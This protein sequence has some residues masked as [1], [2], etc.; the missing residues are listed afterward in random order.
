MQKKEEVFAVYFDEA[1]NDIRLST[2]KDPRYI[3]AAIK[4]AIKDRNTYRGFNLSKISQRHRISQGYFEN[5]FTKNLSYYGFSDSDGE[6]PEVHLEESS[7]FLRESNNS[8]PLGTNTRLF[9]TNYEKSE[10]KTKFDVSSED[11]KSIQEAEN[12]ADSDEEEADVSDSE[13]DYT[14]R[15]RTTARMH[16]KYHF[17]PKF[18]SMIILN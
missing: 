11:I 6:S 13:D 12:E 2:Q 10:G 4:S 16:S 1:G 8:T 14:E 18:R 3:N 15:Q 17:F 9:S 7:S 5:A